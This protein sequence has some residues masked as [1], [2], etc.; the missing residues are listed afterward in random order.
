MFAILDTIFTASTGADTLSLNVGRNQF[1]ISRVGGRVR[2]NRI[3]FAPRVAWVSDSSSSW[4]TLARFVEAR[5]KWYANP[6]P[7]S[8]LQVQTAGLARVVD[9]HAVQRR[10]FFWQKSA[11]ASSDRSRWLH[12]VEM[13]YW[14][15]R[16]R[17]VVRTIDVIDA[18]SMP[19]LHA[20]D[21]V[22]MHFDPR[23]PRVVRLDDGMRTFARDRR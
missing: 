12:L 2:L 23:D 1:D 6:A 14:A 16:V 18:G 20:G 7:I 3:A 9:V 19:G 8:P 11:E 22:Q 15:P 5:I 17:G 10:K 13:E 21:I 4:Q